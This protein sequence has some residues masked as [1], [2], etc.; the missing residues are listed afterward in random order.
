MRASGQRKVVHPA[1]DVPLEFAVAVAEAHAPRTACE[2][3]NTKFESVQRLIAPGNLGSTEREAQ[4]LQL[5]AWDD[6]ALIIV[7]AQLQT[8]VEKRVTLAFTRCAAEVLLTQMTK[9][10]A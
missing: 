6:A 3:S 2:L 4:K 7:D 1:H 5:L 10:S 8:L 9:S